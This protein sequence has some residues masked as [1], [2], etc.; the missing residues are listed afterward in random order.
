MNFFFEK[1]ETLYIWDLKPDKP[2]TPFLS[3]SLSSLSPLL[4][5]SSLS[6]SLLSSF[7]LS[8]PFSSPM[9]RLELA[10]SDEQRAQARSTQAHGLRRASLGAAHPNQPASAQARSGPTQASQ[11]ETPLFQLVRE[12]SSSRRPLFVNSFFVRV[13]RLVAAVNIFAL[14]LSKVDSEVCS[15]RKVLSKF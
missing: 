14:E 5:L 1:P 9:A 7:F 3:L 11:L 2:E 10:T 15:F 8:I 12:L 4:F 6:L 13:R